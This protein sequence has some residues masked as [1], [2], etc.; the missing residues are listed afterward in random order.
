MTTKLWRCTEGRHLSKV[1]CFI[2]LSVLLVSGAWAQETPEDPE[3]PDSPDTPEAAQTAAAEEV[4]EAQETPEAEEAL[5]APAAPPSLVFETKVD[6]EFVKET[7][8]E[9]KAGEVEIRGVEFTSASGKGGFFGSGDAEL[10]AGIVTKLECA[11]SADKKQ[12]LDLVIQF[13]DSEGALIDR[14]TNGVSLKSGTKIF[15]TNHRT[16]KYVVPLIAQVQITASATG[17]N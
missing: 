13:L 5:E 6:F 2:A 3:T 11:T 10:Q 9:G 12:K 1:A 15:E 17:K 16:L 4:A 7:V 8:L 14:V